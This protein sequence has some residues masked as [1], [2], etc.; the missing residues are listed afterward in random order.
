MGERE[1]K[2]G[3]AKRSAGCVHARACVLSVSQ[4]RVCL[5]FSILQATIGSCACVSAMNRLLEAWVRHMFGN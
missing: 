2:D 4:V 3:K 1:W 5:E